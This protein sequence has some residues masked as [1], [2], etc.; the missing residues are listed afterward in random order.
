[1]DKETK[2][3][4]DK[5]VEWIGTISTRVDTINERTKI[6]TLDIKKLEKFVKAQE[7]EKQNVKK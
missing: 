6:H 4:L 5:I 2:D 3:T 1:M 7:K